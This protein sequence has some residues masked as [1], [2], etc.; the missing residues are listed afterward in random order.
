MAGCDRP[1]SPPRD[2]GCDPV[3]TDPTRPPGGDARLRH[4]AP[5]PESLTPL[6]DHAQ[7]SA[8]PAGAAA[9]AIATPGHRARLGAT[10]RRLDP[11]LPRVL[12]LVLGVRAALA[13]EGWLVTSLAPG[14]DAAVAWQGLRVPQS[15]ITGA[16]LAPW[17]RDD[18]IWYQRI[19]ERGFAHDGSAAFFPLFPGTVHVAAVLLGGAYVLAAL[20][21][22]TIAMAA[23]LLLLHRLVRADAGH[24]AADRAVTYLALAPTAFFLLAPYTESLFLALAVGAFLCA[25]R[26]RFLLAGILAGLAATCHFQGVILAVPIGLEMLSDARERRCGGSRP[27][28]PAYLGLALPFAGFLAVDLMDRAVLGFSGGM[29]EVHTG[30]G[31]QRS[32]PWSILADSVRAIG[33]GSHPEEV[34]NLVTMLAM[35]VAIPVMARRF[36]PSYAA[37]TAALVLPLLFRE[38]QYSPMMS[39]VRF[40]LVVFPVFA[41][42][43]VLGAN[44]RLHRAL[45]VAFPVLLLLF[46][47]DFVRFHLVG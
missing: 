34:F 28:R 3:G 39:V 31:D 24:A 47:A 15:G 23:G 4:A 29:V 41:L 42:L 2:R 13:L 20:M 37:L 6:L 45:M 33:S 10:L 26:R 27:L 7:T 12:T 40:A 8:G 11:A 44:R 5:H 25:R 9:L 46:F 14:N 1:V 17:Q 43:G 30:W 18:A 22:S 16:L 36:A 19:A 38:P 21:V 35:L 32:T